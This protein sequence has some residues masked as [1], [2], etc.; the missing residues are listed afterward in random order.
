M[1]LT[2]A[3]WARIEPLLPGRTAR[4]D[5][6]RRDHRGVI[7]GIA[8]KF[9]IGAQQVRMPGLLPPRPGL[10]P[11]K[12]VP[13]R[14]KCLLPAPGRLSRGDSSGRAV[15]DRWSVD[16]RP[17]SAAPWCGAGHGNSSARPER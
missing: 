7:D 9:Q 17:I 15:S 8:W 4:R 16:P 12:R 13:R 5:G 6:R 11:A 2:D 14:R 3:Q 1:P 10:G